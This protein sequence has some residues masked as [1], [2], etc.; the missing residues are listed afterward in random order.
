M[1]HIKS[2]DYSTHPSGALTD[3]QIFAYCLSGHYGDERKRW[4]EQQL[5]R[6]KAIKR[7]AKRTKQSPEN[8]LSELGL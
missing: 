7:L 1:S 8:L 5:R 6:V 2:R 4:A 3:D